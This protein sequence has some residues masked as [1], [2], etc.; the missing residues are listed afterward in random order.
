MRNKLRGFAV[1]PNNMLNEKIYIFLWWWFAFI[2][3]MTVLSMFVWLKR[4]MLPRSRKLFI[5]KFLK[6][7]EVAGHNQDK[8]L[9]QSFTNHFLRVDGVFILHLIADKAG[10]IITGNFLTFQNFPGNIF[11]FNFSKVSLSL[12]IY[13]N[14]IVVTCL[15]CN[16]HPTKPE[17]SQFN[18]INKNN[19]RL[20]EEC[21]QGEKFWKSNFSNRIIWKIN[22]SINSWLDYYIIS[23]KL[24][25]R[26][27]LISTENWH[28]PKNVTNG[29]NWRKFRIENLQFTKWTGSG[30]LLGLLKI[31]YSEIN[32]M[33]TW[34]L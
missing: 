33:S 21:H 27:Y 4:L 22:L 30:H 25:I 11:K 15:I 1:L 29:K 13:S 2:S 20:P 7:L 6:Y 14:P 16:L 3:V 26:N 34:S 32:N 18:F 28:F 17:F 12:V 31:L 23:F 9:W 10:E 5:C 24:I 8:R 19:R